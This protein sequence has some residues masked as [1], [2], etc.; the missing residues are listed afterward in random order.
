[1]VAEF[2]TELREAILDQEPYHDLIERDVRLA[3]REILNQ[4]RPLP[5]DDE[6]AYRAQVSAMHRELTFVG[7]P[8][9]KER[10]PV[11]IEEIFIPLQAEY[12]VETTEASIAQL[13]IGPGENW[14]A[15]IEHAL[16]DRRSAPGA[17]T[18]RVSALEALG[19]SKHTVVLGEPGSGKTTLLKYLATICAEGRLQVRDSPFDASVILPAFIPLRA[20]AAECATR[21][22]DYSLL[23]YFYTFAREHLLLNLPHGFFEDT[24]GDGRCLV[25]LDGLD[26]VWEAG[27]RRTVVDEV[28][29]LVARFPMSRYVVTSRIVGYSDAPLDRQEFTHYTVL[30]LED[31][32]IREFVVKWYRLRERDAIQ[33]NDKTRDLIE[34]I[35]RQPGIHALASNPLLLTIIALVHR[36]E[37]ELPHERVRLYDK[38][39]TAL[40]DTWEEVKGLTLSGT[41]WPFY[42]YRRRLLERLAYEL[43]ASGGAQ[44]NLQTIKA[45]DLEIML[46]RFLSENPRLRLKE[47][48]NASA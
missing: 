43:H 28:K 5:Y 16:S 22:H 44:S 37:A 32:E 25:C 27:G 33:R 2:I 48:P 35:A 1:M 9:L 10:G 23:D 38:C 14:V 17:T 34:T 6:A 29:A 13:E 41:R 31:A 30:P 4:L 21:G 36:V 39:V 18:E 19:H 8:D 7:I 47:D 12:A 26:E 46:A 24:L 42:R 45:G 3:V 11:L 15:A 40:V 20:V